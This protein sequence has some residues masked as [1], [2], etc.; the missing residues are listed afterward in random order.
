MYEDPYYLQHFGVKGMKWG[1]RRS[2]SRRYSQ[3]L[4]IRQSYSRHGAGRR[5]RIQKVV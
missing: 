5:Q 3:W 2:R 1:V 4:D